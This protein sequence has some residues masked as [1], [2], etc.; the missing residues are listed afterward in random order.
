MESITDYV[1]DVDESKWAFCLHSQLNEG[2]G[3]YDNENQLNTS[4]LDSLRTLF[5][6]KYTS[7]EKRVVVCKGIE[8][9]TPVAPRIRNINRI[10]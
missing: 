9:L 4:L 8:I 7:H 2:S 1:D 6:M 10:N 3:L 5:L